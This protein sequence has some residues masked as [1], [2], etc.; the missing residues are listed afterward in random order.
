MKTIAKA[1]L[2][3]TVIALPAFSG[4]A[5]SH[6]QGSSGMM[7]D[8]QMMGQQMM[9]MREQMQQNHELMD[10][11]MAEENTAK[12]NDM[13]Q[14]HMKSMLQQMHGMNQMMGGGYMGGKMMGDEQTGSKMMGN[15][16]MGGMPCGDMEQRMDMMGMRMNMMQMMMEQMMEHQSQVE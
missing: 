13:M 15:K 3:S 14:K 12:R 7:M 2:I 4:N 6:Q 10:K 1:I 16:Q 5:Y 8:P 11:I 9:H